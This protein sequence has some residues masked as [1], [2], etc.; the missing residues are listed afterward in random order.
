[1]ANLRDLPPSR[2]Q[3]Y[4]T[5]PYP[6]SYLAGRR[7]RSQVAT[8]NHLV[9]TPVYGDLVQLGFRRSGLFAYRP[10]CDHCRSCQP[11]RVSV[12]NFQPDRSQRRCWQR[13]SETL[14]VAEEPLK[15]SNEHYALYQRYQSSRHTGGGMDQDS[16]EQYAQFLLQSQ[17]DTRLVTF[18]DQTGELLM[19][20]M[21]DVL[22]VGL[23]AVYTFFEPTRSKD[24]LGT[25]GI[26]WQ[27]AEAYRL[28]LPHVYL[29]YFIEESRKMAYKNK[30]RPAEVFCHG[31]W[32][33][34]T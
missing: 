18:R 2:I 4:V 22:P 12:Q 9:T 26:L 31:R 8:P 10:Y 30:F 14:S 19:I 25:F 1:M 6:C 28:N 23:S 13:L 32:S 24:S 20:S 21:I 27:I 16:R 15:F 3:F 5:A 33:P 29:G 17:V 34:L 11:I 7:A